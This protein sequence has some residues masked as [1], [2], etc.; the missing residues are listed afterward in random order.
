MDSVRSRLVKGAQHKMGE[1]HKVQDTSKQFGNDDM[2][3]MQILDPYNEEPM[4]EERHSPLAQQRL[5]VNPKRSQCRYPKRQ[6]EKATQDLNVRAGTLLCTGTS[7]NLQREGTQSLVAKKKDISENRASRNFDLMITNDI[8]EFINPFCTRVQEIGEPSSRNIDNTDVHSFQ[9]QSHDYRWTRDHHHCE[10]SWNP[11]CQFKQ[12]DACHADLK[13]CLVFALTVSLVLERRTFKEAMADYAWIRSNEDGTSSVRLQI[14]SLGTILLLNGYARKWVSDF[15]ESFAPVAR[16]E[17]EVYV[18]QP[19]GYRDPGSSR[20]SLP[21]QK[22]S[23]LDADHAG[24]LDTRKSTSGGIQFLGDKLVSWMSKK[25]NCT[26]MSSA[27]AEYVAL[28][29]SCAQ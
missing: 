20:K 7:F 27:E 16:L 24:C 22:V 19:D 11:S 29:A 6:L 10:Q 28:S 12:D 3:M 2:L 8:D 14:K 15:E 26:A 17:A 1:N 13:M 21:T 9:P 23:F 25:Q 18:A 4:A 5:K